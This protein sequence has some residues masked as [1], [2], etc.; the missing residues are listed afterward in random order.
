MYSFS[1]NGAFHVSIALVC[2]FTFLAAGLQNN[3]NAYILP[4]A[5]CDL[6]LTS[7]EM[8]LLNAVFLAGMFFCHNCF[9]FYNLVINVL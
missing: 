2:G 8:G 5:R 1:E 9:H 4:S 3:L 6:S 7:N